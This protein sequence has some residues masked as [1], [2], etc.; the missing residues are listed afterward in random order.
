MIFVGVVYLPCHVRSTHHLSPALH[1]CL[2][3]ELETQK[4]YVPNYSK[5]VSAWRLPG[6]PLGLEPL[7]CMPGLDMEQRAHVGASG[8]R[9]P[10]TTLGGAGGE[11]PSG[12]AFVPVARASRR[13][14]AARQTRCEASGAADGAEEA[15]PRIARARRVRTLAKMVRQMLSQ[16]HQAISCLG[17]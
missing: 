8:K 16:Y 7:V 1:C 3:C 13:A 5:T 14:T 4:L 6:I 2:M 15:R 9:L 11:L 17:V 12:G 10:R